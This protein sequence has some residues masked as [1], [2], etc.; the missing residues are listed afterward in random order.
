MKNMCVCEGYGIGTR[1]RV[2]FEKENDVGVHNNNRFPSPKKRKTQVC[3]F[4]RFL[5]PKRRKKRATNTLQS[6]SK[7]RRAVFLRKMQP[8]P[9][10]FQTCKPANLQEGHA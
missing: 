5:F 9:D 4:R 6:T 2:I 8:R 1:Y 10:R 3:R 7:A